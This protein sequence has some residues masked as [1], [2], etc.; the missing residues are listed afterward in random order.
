MGKGTAST[1]GAETVGILTYDD[2]VEGSPSTFKSA[3]VAPFGH[4]AQFIKIA[5]QTNT[6]RDYPYDGDGLLDG[7]TDQDQ[8]QLDNVSSGTPGDAKG[9]LIQMV[10]GTAGNIGETRRIIAHAASMQVTL[11]SNLPNTPSVGDGY[12][13]MVDCQRLSELMVKT[14]FS[15]APPSSADLIAIFYDY[16]RTLGS[17]P[18]FRKSIRFHDALRTIDNL[19]MQSIETEEASY[20]H[21]NL[22]AVQVRGAMGAKV[23]LVAISSGNLSQ[24]A[25]GI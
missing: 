21:A 10:S 19:G 16:H 20:Y 6:V 4:A 13:L 7:V 14:E 2:Y 18:A 9:L 12:R 8:I 3:H 25:C 24:W 17:S 15:V 1:S 11:N 23:R 22:L 5:S